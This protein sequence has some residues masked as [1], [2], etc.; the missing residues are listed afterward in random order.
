MKKTIMPIILLCLALG[1]L[2]AQ[3]YDYFPPATPGQY[4]YDSNTYTELGWTDIAVSQTEN[5]SDVGITYTWLTDSWPSEGSFYLMSPSGTT[6]QIAA[7]QTSGTYSYTLANFM[8]EPMNGNWRLWIQ[9]SYGDGGHVAS[10]ITVSFHYFLAG[11]PD[12]PTA[13]S[14]ATGSTGVAIDGNLSWT[15]GANT[16]TYD[17][18]FGPTGSMVQV[19]TGA[20][21]GVTGSFA[22][23][24]L[25]YLGP[26]SW[27]VVA[28]NSTR[29]SVNGPIWNFTTVQDPNA[30]II[31]TGADLIRLPINAYYGYSY[32]QTYYYAAE[33]GTPGT[34]TS[35]AYQW[36]GVGTNPSSNLWKV[37]MGHS[38]NTAFASN[39]AWETGLTQVFD[40]TVNCPASSGWV[41]IPLD[42]GFSY[43]GMD[44]LV[45]AVYEYQPGFDGSGS[46]FYNTASTVYRGMI[47]YSDGT[48]P[49]PLAPPVA[50]GYYLYYPN[51]MMN[52]TPPVAGAPAAPLLTYPG[53]HA[54]GIDPYNLAFSWGPDLINGGLPEGY[55]FY[56]VATADLTEPWNSDDF[57]AAAT[58]YEDVSSGFMPPFGFMYNTN[59]TWTVEAYTTGYPNAYA[60]PPYDF[61]SRTD[62]TI[63]TFPYQTDFETWPPQDWDLTGGTYSFV[64]YA[65]GTG[66]HW[67]MANY[68]GQTSGNTDIMTTPPILS[69]DPVQ[70]SFDWSHAYNSTYPDD[71]LT[72]QI[73]DDLAN[74]N[75]LWFKDNTDLD[76]ADGASDTTPGTGALATIPIPGTYLGDPFWIRFYGYSG[77]GPDLFIDDVTI[78]VPLDHDVGVVSI[79]INP[80]VLSS[81]VTPM[82]TVMNYGVN[83]ESF[84]V[85]MTIGTGYDQS[86]MVNSLA[87]GMTEQV[88]FP[89]FSPVSGTVYGVQAQTLLPGD[90]NAAN[91][92]MSSNLV[93]LDLMNQA[94]A[95]VAYSGGG[96]TGPA[97]FSLGDPGTIV[98]L[99]ADNPW[100]GRFLSGADWINGG[101]W[102]SE[103]YD[104]GTSLGGSWWQIDTSTGAGTN[105][106]GDT[107]VI[108]GVAVDP[109]A[110]MIYGSTSTDLYTINPLN[111]AKTHVGN[112]G[113]AGSVFISIAYNN[114]TQILYGMDLVTDALYTIN[115]GTGA[116]TLVGPMGDAFNYAQDLAFDQATGLLYLAGYTTT[117][118]LYWVDTNTGAASLIAPFQGGWE[119]DGFVIPY[120]GLQAPDLSI[121]A[122]GTLSWGPVAG[123]TGYKIYGGADPYGTLT[124][125]GSTTATSWLDP[126]FPQ[127]M[128]F[129]QVTADDTVIRGPLQIRYEGDVYRNV[130]T[131]RSTEPQTYR[132]YT[133]PVK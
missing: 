103:Y 96:T 17:L 123:A 70:L 2:S 49:D 90:E 67:A 89:P 10:N 124:Y 69:N 14:P 28:H 80:V 9:D 18:W 25:D 132:R 12:M 62:P 81:P 40:G 126:A 115:P 106:G 68:W 104:A 1:F 77:Y 11:A 7:G 131:V 117:G 128:Q 44:N 129:Y 33:I 50:N 57:F 73:S 130:G 55:N 72:V 37:Y 100:Q 112:F 108:T 133:P 85:Q 48:N 6:V 74:W 4:A 13:P 84:N 23:S 41:N 34:I 42:T 92:Q 95:D 30:V 82:A 51:I 38:T 64:Q 122:D 75:D 107:T 99:P 20:T 71:A 101:W 88:S 65:D 8:G 22:Y 35:I 61:T 121:A 24:G 15:F 45:V 21:A 36:N 87:P 94:Y 29:L 125:L 54:T 105:M 116:A 5:V 79:D 113:V 3:Q 98:D 91:N 127:M 32:S 27:Q 86:V 110:G 26:Y 53:E 31:G 39:T 109:V 19:V 119:I 76:S 43:N 102:G 60:W 56:V 52:L 46:Y 63:T 58:P 114:N 120:G 93:M 78:G 16:E 111:G 83:T 47:F 97:T 118:S 59:Y 66:N